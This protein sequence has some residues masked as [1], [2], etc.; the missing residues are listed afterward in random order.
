MSHQK[1]ALFILCVTSA[2][3]LG[4]KTVSNGF[5]SVSNGMKSMGTSIASHTSKHS[6][7]TQRENKTPKIGGFP[8]NHFTNSP[9]FEALTHKAP[10]QNPFVRM[11]QN[12][13]GA[14]SKSMDFKPKVVMPKDEVSLATKVEPVGGGFLVIAGQ[15]LENRGDFAAAEVQVA[16]RFC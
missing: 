8:S 3:A 5:A 1:I 4:C 15:G 7:F 13:T 9:D 16:L 12:T 2:S 6:I 14:I 10:A 11:W